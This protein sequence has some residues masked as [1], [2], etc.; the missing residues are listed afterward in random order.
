MIDDKLR[1]AADQPYPIA[2]ATYYSIVITTAELDVN[3]LPIL[4]VLFT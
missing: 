1:T 2:T 4:D 3:S